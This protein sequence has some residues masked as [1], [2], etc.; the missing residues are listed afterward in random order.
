M[1]T[2]TTVPPPFVKNP[3]Q[4]TP[5]KMIAM[6]QASM[7]PEQSRDMLAM[8]SGYEQ[9]FQM[10]WF[11]VVE[12]KEAD[13]LSHIAMQFPAD[14]LRLLAKNDGTE[15][16]EIIERLQ[17]RGCIINAFERDG[18]LF[19]VIGAPLDF[20]HWLAHIWKDGDDYAGESAVTFTP[21]KRGGL[22]GGKVPML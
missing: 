7:T 19:A 6:A 4:V 12:R 17:A 22:V 13:K 14:V 1:N 18:Q 3:V 10:E 5:D 20:V 2:I 8:L 16:W 15:K 11:P 21:G 9:I